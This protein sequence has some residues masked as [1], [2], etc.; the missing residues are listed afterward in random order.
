MQLCGLFPTAVSLPSRWCDQRQSFAF[1]TLRG[2]WS[3]LWALKL[4]S[5]VLPPFKLASQFQHSR[6]RAGQGCSGRSTEGRQCPPWSPSRWI[7]NWG[8]TYAPRPPSEVARQRTSAPIFSGLWGG[9]LPRA[10]GPFQSVRFRCG[11]FSPPAQPPFPGVWSSPRW[12]MPSVRSAPSPWPWPPFPSRG[13]SQ[14][15]T[16]SSEA[17]LI[18]MLQGWLSLPRCCWASAA[19]LPFRRRVC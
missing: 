6:P 1:F 9:S 7:V 8:Q 14:S 17:S 5:T 18:S 10:K 12:S 15:W 4:H 19:T 16:G 13:N 11:W 3:V 2:S